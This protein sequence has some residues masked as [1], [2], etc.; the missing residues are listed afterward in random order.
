MAL[1]DLLVEGS[2]R[3]ATEEGGVDSMAE[4]RVKDSTASWG[5]SGEVAVLVC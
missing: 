4:S 2:G 3:D 1:S 5:D